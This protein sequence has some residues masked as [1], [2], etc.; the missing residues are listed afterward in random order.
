MS[1]A[2]RVAG[3]LRGLVVEVLGASAPLE[4]AAWALAG[5]GA[6]VRRDRPP[7]L[8][9]GVGWGAGAVAETGRGR[10][11]LALGEAGIGLEAAGARL[12]AEGNDPLADSGL[13]TGT[14]DYACG[15]TL[16]AA[17]LAAWLGEDVFEVHVEAVVG[18]VLLP[19][20]A[21]SAS[22]PSE[23]RPV[24]PAGAVCAE[25]GAEGD[26]EA[27]ERLLTT[28]GPAAHDPE[29][30]A[31]L[32]QEWR[33]PVT[34]CRP[35]SRAGPPRPL[36]CPPGRFE[37]GAEVQPAFPAG[38]SGRCA[39]RPPLVGLRVLDL[40]AMW[41]GPLCTWLLAGLGA[42]VGKVEPS[43]RLDGLRFDERFPGDPAAAAGCSAWFA[44]LNAGKRRLDLD[45]RTAEAKA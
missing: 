20:R 1:A 25:L 4:W 5:L 30:L 31:A 29:A 38:A 44:A 42:E 24:G 43:A 3:P 41:A 39:R 18:Q 8:P 16:A 23:L 17:G 7:S 19:L 27:F 10:P 13:P 21:G 2:G 11:D 36:P 32:A 9:W 37:A 15:V 40:T 45:L 35:R 12:H 33:L 26:R 34:P 6:A 14:I 22:Q 28:A